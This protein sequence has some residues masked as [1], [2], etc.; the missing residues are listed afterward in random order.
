MPDWQQY[1]R[2]NL[3]L[4]RALPADEAAAIEEI[5]RQ[6]EDAYLEALNRGLSPE[7]AAAEAKLHITDWNQL[8]DELPCNK[9]YLTASHALREERRPRM[10]IAGWIESLA[11]DARYAARRLGRSAGFTFVA[12]LTLG[13]GIG[14]NTVIF[15]A[16]NSLLLN[17]AGLPD[18]NR[19]LAFGVNYEK[20][21]N[22]STAV[23]LAEFMDV[24]DSKDVFS[25]AAA[26]TEGNYNYTVTDFP[27]RLL[28]LRVSWQWFEVF[29]VKPLLGRL[30][31]AEED[32]PNMNR[33]VVL[34]HGTW[35][36]LFGGDAS[37]I[38]RTIELNQQPYKV[39]GVMGPEFRS[40]DVNLWTPLGLPPA[41]YTPRSRFNESYELIARV[42]SGVSVEQALAHVA[43]LTD[44][45]HQ[46][47]E[48]PGQFSRDNGWSI[49]ARPYP[50]SL[51]GDLKSPMFVLMGAVAFVLLIACA[52]VAGLMIARAAGQKREL[53]VRSALGAGRWLLIRQ[54]LT[55]SLLIAIGGLLAGVFMAYGGI[56]LLLALA[57]QNLGGV[58][59]ELDA[60]VMGFTALIS[61]AA[62]IFFGLI[63]ALQITG[64]HS[65]ESLKEGGRF[66]TATRRQI[67]LRSVL[68]TLEIAMA[69]VLL[70]GAGLFLRSLYNLQ[71]VDTGFDAR[72]VMTGIV[73][74]PPL[75]YR[76]APDKQ[77]TFHHAVLERLASMPGV[78]HAATGIPIPFSGDAG[79]AFAIEGAAN[80]PGQPVPAGR[81]RVISP[82]YFA[83]LQIPLL[84]GRT[85]TDQDTA[86][87]EPVVVIDENLA[88]QYWPNE[89]PI[90]K[91]IRRTT[92]T[93]QWTT[94]VGIVR[95]IRHTELATDSGRG[96][97]YYPVY[98][99]P[100]ATTFAILARTTGEPTELSN[101]I[102]E[103]V[104]AADPS[105][106][107]FELRTMEDRVLASLG[108]RRF[109]VQLMAVFAALGAFMAA[110]GLYGVISYIVA[111]Q[112]HEIGIRMA[113]GARGDQIVAFVIGHGMR[114]TLAGIVLGS[115]GAFVLARSLSSQLFEVSSFDPGTF[116]LMAVMVSVVA[117]LACLIPARRATTVDPVDAC[118]S[119]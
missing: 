90:G 107:V 117:F 89:D 48:F 3:R 99:T 56:R 119:E 85:F 84:R 83:T 4:A 54:T 33:V 5:A 25:A 35:Q 20:L 46:S 11:R 78:S 71:Q 115:F 69:L 70:V 17:P 55:E 60:T 104:R 75:I 34:D 88:R 23:S 2:Q 36:R 44:R 63:P 37:I 9:R 72:G 43:V 24:R 68:V 15:S 86:N 64:A 118:R 51:A 95:H 6:L 8:S 45:V 31:A 1:V 52:N 116:A 77:R 32:Q 26:A 67:H 91:R 79:G 50:E 98:Q 10:S 93:A 105:Q 59:I 21:G 97:H 12:V 87:S 81:L 65:L 112:T 29:G 100:Q 7:E 61:I 14:G 113:L 114:L 58:S 38:D 19:I 102:R 109:A 103:A 13:L 111:Q 18:A 62:G 76:D 106:S 30:F 42:K 28:G 73:A 82:D 49:W 94:I 22:R 108:S 39:I 53:A 66:G 57:P 27:E 96:V 16:I 40:R 74:L 101:A 47:N 92:S 80:Q 110:I 41:L